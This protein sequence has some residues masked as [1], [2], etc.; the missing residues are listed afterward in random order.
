MEIDIQL[1]RDTVQ[2][3]LAEDLGWPFFDKT[4]ESLNIS[5]KATANIVLREEAVVCGLEFAKESFLKVD[6]DSVVTLKLTDGEREKKGQV[7][8]SITAQAK[9][10]LAAE[11]TALNFMQRLSGIATLTSQFVAIA[12]KY[13]V[14]ILDTRK[15]TP[16]MR[17]IEKYAVACGGGVNHRMGLYDQVLIKDNH[18]MINGIEKA[19][20]QAA[21]NCEP[22]EVLLEVDNMDQLETGYSGGLRRFLL[23]NMDPSIMAQARKVYPDAYLEASG[24]IDLHNIEQVVASGVNAVSIGA[25]THSVKAIDISLELL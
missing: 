1:I 19:V 25:L 7:V 3:A 14:D 9:A 22:G 24:G 16:T 2:R 10:I 12:K 11:R 5:G 20:R 17:L 8:A 15:T 4:S 6:N 23:D 21:S 18:I 13:N